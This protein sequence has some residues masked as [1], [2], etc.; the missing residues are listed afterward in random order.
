MLDDCVG[1]DNRFLVLVVWFYPRRHCE[2]KP[3][4]PGYRIYKRLFYSL[5]PGAAS[6]MD[7]P[8]PRVGKL[9]SET[10]NVGKWAQ[11]HHL[12]LSRQLLTDTQT[13]ARKKRGGKTYRNNRGQ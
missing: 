13:D 8:N 10:G 12:N 3:L 6:L 7:V 9:S 1:Q 5:S 11:A 4:R 2:A